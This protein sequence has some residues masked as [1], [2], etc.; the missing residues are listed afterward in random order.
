MKRK[1]FTRNSFL[2]KMLFSIVGL[3]C[4]PL[5]CIQLHMIASTN[6]EFQRENIAY[7]QQ[8]VQSL[9]LSFDNQLHSISASAFRMRTDT[10]VIRPLTEDVRGYDVQIVASKINNYGL[11]SPLINSV[12]VYYVEKD[13]ILYNTNRYSLRNVCNH[14]FSGD[15][16]GNADFAAFLKNEDATGFF[17]TGKYPD[18]MGKYLVVKKSISQYGKEEKTATAFFV[19]DD[20]RFEKWCSIFVPNGESFAVFDQENNYLLG[21]S[22]FF[23]QISDNDAFH[24]FL[25]NYEPSYIPANGAD[26]ILYK[27][28]DLNT[29]YTY[30]A[31]VAKDTAEATFN[32]Y[33]T[34]AVRT[35]VITVIL[36]AILLSV[37]LYINYI[38]VHKIV[39]KHISVDSQ[40]A[41]VSELELINTHLFAQD[42][43]I[44]SQNQLLASLIVG[45]L[46]SGMGAEAAAIEKHFPSDTY[47]CFTAAL[48]FTP[49]T[50][51]QSAEVCRVFAAR[52]KGKLVV[53]TVPYRTEMV[54]VY[55]TEGTI[56]LEQLQNNLIEAVTS[57]MGQE[58]EIRMGS[59][60]ESAS[61]IQS[62]YNN[63]LLTDRLFGESHDP[64]PEGYPHSLVSDFALHVSNGDWNSALLDL[65][66]LEN[67]N[68][69]LKP[70][71]KRFVHLK[72]L[73]N[74]LT[75]ISKS[76]YTL[77]D[78]EMNH[79]LS[80]TNG[81]HL[82]NMMRRSIAG[83]QNAPKTSG[84][85]SASELRKKLLDYV[86]R[87][88]SSSEMC[89][90]SAADYLKTSIYTVSRIFKEATGSGFKEYITEKRLQR[91]C[92]LLRESNMS[93]SD[94]GA[95]CGFE[96]A[97]YF[98]VIFRNKYGMA[99]SKFR[100]E[101]DILMSSDTPPERNNNEYVI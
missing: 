11:D 31:S 5:I 50:T 41:K 24:N 67:L 37:T 59:V 78:R 96:N 93:I 76:G 71:V 42:E 73:N 1:L 52:E 100:K 48:S 75:N 25:K 94:I 2:L 23:T 61:E 55:A 45:D 90:S 53:T 47:R 19:M 38:P 101:A 65:D 12:G 3:I 46:L 8:A 60:V 95:S 43:R 10:E 15:T 88:F 99:P 97:D 87:N 27:Y 57:V 20:E 80:Y 91:A 29:G 30:M 68:R 32:H 63:A 39:K 79:L 13:M 69:E 44:T 92:S 77:S 21:S 49:M 16:Q 70:S 85:E 58:P 74:Y 14:F 28:H 66:G 26:M 83:I 64:Q 9:A 89:L 81:Q 86:N 54:F 22:D 98:T 62:S 34:Q 35:I 82:Y 51:A 4:I 72:V 17:Y 56:D 84:E 6:R 40:K 18:A 33:A 7:Y 36:V